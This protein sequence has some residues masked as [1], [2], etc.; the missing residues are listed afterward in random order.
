MESSAQTRR[1]VL[2]SATTIGI[3]GAAL[4]VVRPAAAALTENGKTYGVSTH[5]HFG[6]VMAPWAVKRFVD[7]NAKFIF[8]TIEAAPRVVG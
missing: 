8:A 2:R 6:R 3:A 5:P 7:K 1:D 4:T